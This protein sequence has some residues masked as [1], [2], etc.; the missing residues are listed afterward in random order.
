MKNIELVIPKIKDYYYEKKLNED[1]DTMSYNAGYDLNLDRYHYDTGCIDFPE[2]LWEDMYL[3]RIREHR[4]FAFIK[5]IDINEYV[6][7]VN[8]S[9]NNQLNRY[10]CGIVIEARY[11]NSG[12]SKE[13]LRLLM[14]E[15]NRNGITYLY[16]TFEEE[17]DRALK[18]FLDLGFEVIEET[19]WKKFNK[20]VRG[21]IVKGK[22]SNYKIN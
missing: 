14:K 18:I 15:A 8:Y 12:Y 1:E 10:E 21:V 11:R 16:D 4:Y 5:D 20:D 17:R 2:E 3:K 7:S 19:T 6:G 22:T 13:A 9:Y